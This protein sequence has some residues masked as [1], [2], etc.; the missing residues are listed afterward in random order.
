M[1]D[2]G[3][4]EEEE[5]EDEKDVEI[6]ECDVCEAEEEDCV[7]LSFVFPSVCISCLSRV[8]CISICSEDIFV[9]SALIV[10]IRSVSS[11]DA[12]SASF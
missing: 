3:E 7:L 10:S 5:E 1:C 12:S 8:S 4:N 2:L 9:R 6:T 11:S